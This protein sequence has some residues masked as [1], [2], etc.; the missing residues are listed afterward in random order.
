ARYDNGAV[1]F[2]GEI[3]NADGSRLLDRT[4]LNPISENRVQQI[5][6]QS[7][8]GGETWQKTFDAIYI[9]VGTDG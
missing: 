7:R 5:I 8:D 4:T 1:R 2:Q 6:E 9:R 3:R